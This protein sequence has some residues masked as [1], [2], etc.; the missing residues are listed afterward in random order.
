VQGLASCSIWLLAA[1]EKE[2]VN[3]VVKAGEI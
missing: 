1:G 3:L 2:L